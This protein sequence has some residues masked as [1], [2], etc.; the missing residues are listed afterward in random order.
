MLDNCYTFAELKEKFQ[1]DTTLNEISKQIIYA[2]RRGVIIEK[3]FK[4]GPTYFRIID[5][6][7]YPNEVWKDHPNSLYNLQVSNL[8]RVR[9]KNTQAFIGHE[10]PQHYIAI[11]RNNEHLLAHRLVMETFAPIE[12]SNLYIVDHINGLR[13]DNRL[14]NLR[15]ATMSTNLMYKNENWKEI[16]ELLAKTI[17][18]K[19]YE[20][21]KKQ[22][23]AL[24][25]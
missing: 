7:N 11:H 25:E 19:G 24:L 21:V 1:W 17:E 14:E 22:L 18:I 16:G 4:K 10:N 2:R 6:D 3:A 15:W 12:N 20:T 5:V 23:L 8:G 9:D 13:T